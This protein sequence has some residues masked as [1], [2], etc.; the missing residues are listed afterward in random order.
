MHCYTI[1][2]ASARGG[3]R[4]HRG[5]GPTVYSTLADRQ[6]RIYVCTNNGVQQLT[7]TGTGYASRVFRRRDGLV[8]DECNTHSQF[9]D[10]ADRYWAGTLGG[11]SAF[12]SHIRTADASER[13]RPL[14]WI[15]LQVDGAD[16]RVPA[17]AVLRLPPG[18]RELRV[19]YA[20]LTS[21]REEESRYRAVLHG[22]DTG[23]AE[24]SAEH[25]RTFT[26]LPA[27]SYRLAV[28]ARDFR[29]VH[30]TQIEL[31]IEVA[32]YWWQRPL[33]QALLALLGLLVAVA[34]VLLYNRNLRGR[35]RRLRAEVAARTAELDTANRR[36][37]E[38]SYSDPLTGVANR[39]R[40][41]E[42]LEAA[43]ERA[44]AR[45]LPLGVIVID[46]DHFKEYNDR[47]GHLAG[48]AA[49]RAV[50]HALESARR[51]QD[52]VARYGGE[53]FACLL[54]DAD[55]QATLAVAERMRALVEALPPRTLG[56]DEQTVTISAGVLTGVPVAGATPADLLA[57][58]DAALFEAKRAGRN[59]VRL[60]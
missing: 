41:N 34:L 36:L 57:R 40:L 50:A 18:V 4:R 17:D 10:S 24:W 42:A 48:D 6:G 3:A 58:A 32:P 35:Q 51:Q 29:G 15:D 47:H 43:V 21:E 25:V 52:L 28:E 13:P 7:P 9:V 54:V 45:G 55:P 2:P 37:T 1:S 39:R 38:L 16:V 60:A 49:L 11:L 46:V 53:E 22:Y 56:N 31:K 14:R 19:G 5:S 30:G 59:R 44:L 33:L 8:H 12:D 27:G 20:L 26:R 23:A